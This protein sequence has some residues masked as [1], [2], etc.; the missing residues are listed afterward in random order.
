MILLLLVHQGRVTREY[1]KTVNRIAPERV[2]AGA[3]SRE[4]Y[5]DVH[6]SGILFSGFQYS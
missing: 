1:D 4:D 2:R 5:H 6:Q 3:L